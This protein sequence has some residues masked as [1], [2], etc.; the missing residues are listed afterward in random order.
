MTTQSEL[1]QSIDAAFNA[2][3]LAGSGYQLS[4]R[5]YHG[6]IQGRRV[7]AYYKR[8]MRGR[9]GR[10]GTTN[11][12]TI[13]LSARL[14]VRLFVG[15][16]VPSED[17]WV[18]R[19]FHRSMMTVED[20]AYD[21]LSVSAPDEIWA[22]D[23]LA[24]RAAKPAILRLSTPLHGEGRRLLLEPRALH[25]ELWAFDSFAETTLQ[26][27]VDDL[28]VVAEAGEGI[29]PPHQTAT[30]SV[31]ERYL[32]DRGRFAWYGLGGCLLAG[33]ALFACSILCSAV[34]MFLD[35]LRSH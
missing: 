28:F 34:P 12:L 29:L 21:H 30:E 4:G 5:Q 33:C 15:A 27:I 31:F 10:G 11:S 32:R 35:F 14:N 25:T 1:T 6:T 23:L 2:L 3:Y 22:R 24:D 19:L 7:D 16:K 20:P 13:Y 18:L 9:H 17:E 8:P 26:Q